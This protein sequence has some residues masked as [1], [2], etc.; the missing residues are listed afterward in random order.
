MVAYRTRL[1]ARL[2]VLLVAL[3][4][5]E[6]SALLFSFA[7]TLTAGGISPMA[8]DLLSA[9]TVLLAQRCALLDA[10][11]AFGTAVRRHY[12]VLEGRPPR[13][14][15]IAAAFPGRWLALRHVRLHPELSK[16]GRA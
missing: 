8:F 7:A 1:K 16:G 14:I 12:V 6:V 10:R 11:S 4:I 2:T 13:T 15:W 9:A 5:T 3:A